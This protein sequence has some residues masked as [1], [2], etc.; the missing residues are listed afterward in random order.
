MIPINPA[1]ARYAKFAWGSL[2]YVL[3][4]IM[5][6]AFVRA[7]GSGAGCGNHW[8]SCNGQVIP[9]PKDVEQ[10]IEFSHRLTSGLFGLLAI[11]LV[12][13]A[14]RL[15]PKGHRVRAAA[16]V[17]LI[18]TVTEALIGMLLVRYGW[19]ASDDSVERAIAMS[20][21]LINTF[22]LLTAMTLLAWWASGGGGMRLR[23]QGG[24]GLS[25][26]VGVVGML[27]LGVS[28]AVTALGDTLYP[29]REMAMNPVR[30]FLIDLRV[31]HPII[32]I[33]VG[34]YLLLVAA[35]V[36][37]MRPSETVSRYARGVTTLF[38]IQL[39]IG[40]VNVLLHAPVWMQLVHLLFADLVWITFMLLGAAALAV[41]APR[42]EAV[43]PDR[44]S[45]D[46]PQPNL[47]GV[48]AAMGR[49]G[50]KDYMIL[51]KP[52][53]IS[54]LL[55]TTLAAMFI[56][57]NGWPGGWLL[58]AV[59]IGGYMSAG[60]ANTINMV[61]DRDID[62]TMK[63]TSTRPTVT[64]K[65]S[66]KDALL[67]GFGLAIGSFV[68]LAWAANLLTALL[69]LAGL[70]FYV[71]VYTMLLKRRTWHN[72][73]IGGA[74]GAFPP[75][76]GWA[77]VAGELTPLAWWL[78]AVI[79]VWTPVHFW[80]L[81]LLIKEDYAKAG[82]PMLPAVWGERMT[83]MQIGLYLVLTV[84]VTV[85]A[86]LQGWLGTP[87]AIG[88][89]TLNAILAVRWLG[90]LRMPDRPHAVSL[91]KFSM[92]YLALL[93]VIAAVDRAVAPSAVAVA[94][95]VSASIGHLDN[96]VADASSSLADSRTGSSSLTVSPDTGIG[97]R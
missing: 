29:V 31:F 32:A 40:L 56:A 74:A 70:V 3:V 75:L 84:M 14:F 34:L 45:V 59:A 16:V 23:G 83:V 20:G 24:V 11:G 50:I 43:E 67:F 87:Y 77:A 39:V 9:R 37:R 58:L 48:Q 89:T 35:L 80:A 64:Q 95:T 61:I 68:L 1:A 78:F 17:T 90:L 18:F 5:W 6:G 8:P 97:V 12:V 62:G 79:F 27:L 30:H 55:F 69:S 66:A 94:D 38:L 88:A 21:H 65:V 72:I 10:L 54:L 82:V 7:T 42:R 19:V 73:V 25:L 57:A 71:V 51:T 86:Y 36:A 26:F 15:F 49:P 53:V 2:A 81:A 96:R 13:F 47:T 85:W 22:F 60:A 91:Y 93:F 4:V 44:A 92:L 33:S 41:N 28:G 63:R 76:V 52:R 46:S